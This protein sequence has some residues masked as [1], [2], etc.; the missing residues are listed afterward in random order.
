MA[1][2]FPME[3]A[4][5]QAYGRVETAGQQR[6]R[7]VHLVVAVGQREC[8]GTLHARSEQGLFVRARRH[9]EFDGRVRVSVQRGDPGSVLVAPRR[10]DDGDGLAAH[11]VQLDGEP[12]CE[13]VVAA[14]HHVL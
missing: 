1:A 8:G 14:D 9:L 7:H 5:D 13:P 6:R 10:Q 11:G 2:A 3:H 4:D 12:V